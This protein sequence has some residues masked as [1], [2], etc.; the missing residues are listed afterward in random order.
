MPAVPANWDRPRPGSSGHASEPNANRQSQSWLM[1]S[2]GKSAI[3]VVLI[4]FSGILA[5]TAS[6]S[7]KATRMEVKSQCLQDAH[8][9]MSVPPMPNVEYLRRQ[10]TLT[11]NGTITLS[12]AS[13]R[14]EPAISAHEL[15]QTVARPPKES[16][17]PALLGLRLFD[18]PSGSPARRHASTAGTTCLRLG[19][20]IP[21]RA[22][23][24][25][26]CQRL[27]SKDGD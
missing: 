16:P 6:A 20:A 22:F 10:L 9:P 17:A 24:L 2:V 23:R 1:R 19:V 5:S 25:R 15:W 14:S 27:R 4:F 7:A 3:V 12:P 11:W 18:G 21:A 8:A 13:P 26:D